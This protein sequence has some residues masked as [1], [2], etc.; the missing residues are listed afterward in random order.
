[1]LR[2]AVGWTSPLLIDE[3][4]SARPGALDGGF[5]RVSGVLRPR[6]L[7]GVP[8]PYVSVTAAQ[9]LFRTGYELRD[10]DR[11]TSLSSTS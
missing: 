7:A 11:T 6:Q 10:I 3:D 5:R 2:A 4:G 1:M 9:R 8:V